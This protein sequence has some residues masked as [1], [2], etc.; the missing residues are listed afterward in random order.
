MVTMG[1]AGAW[2]GAGLQYLC[3]GLLHGIY[4]SINH[5]WRVLGGEKLARAWSERSRFSKWV[6]NFG[7]LSMTLSA[8]LL[9]QVFFRADSVSNARGMLAGL[10]G[11]RGVGTDK[12][13]VAAR[14]ASLGGWPVQMLISH[15]LVQIGSTSDQIYAL[16]R[17]PLAALI[18]FAM[19]NSQEIMGRFEPALNFT[20]R[21][22]MRLLAWQPT[23]GWA[24]ATATG[25]FWCLGLLGY[26]H[27][28][29][30]FQ[31]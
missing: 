27:R 10:L 31:F 8:V 30:Y 2:H 5:L 14:M 16:A 15:G 12:I 21:P 3:F 23:I 6:I 1:L 18:I 11:L 26:T 28:F 9:A 20:P 22:V 4:I 7:F 25:M 24:A 19:P 17:F 29:L 13:I